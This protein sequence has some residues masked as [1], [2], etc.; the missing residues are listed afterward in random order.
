M[1]IHVKKMYFG[2]LVQK[3]LR[4]FLDH[5]KQLG[6]LMSFSREK[7]LPSIINNFS[8]KILIKEKYIALF[9]RLVI[10]H[11]IKPYRD[12]LHV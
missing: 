9:R 11:F 8:E 1:N 7:S 4:R 12:P 10:A 3:V 6:I 5:G 2:L